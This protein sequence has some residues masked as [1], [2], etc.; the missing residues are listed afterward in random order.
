MRVDR[1]ARAYVEYDGQALEYRDIVYLRKTL[2]APKR[3][4]FHYVSVNGVVLATFEWSD[5]V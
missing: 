3:A 5:V 4:T 2:G 1:M